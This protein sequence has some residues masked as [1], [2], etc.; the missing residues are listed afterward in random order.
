MRPKNTVF[1][2]SLIAI[3]A[4]QDGN[5][6]PQETSL[7]RHLFQQA[8]VF[9]DIGA[10]IGYF[11]CLARHAGTKTIAIEPLPENLN[12]LYANL[13]IN[14]WT[15]VEVLP[16]GLS[17]KPGVGTF[18]G[19]GTGASLLAGW[20]GASEV[21]KRAV[22]LTTLDNVLGGRFSGKKLI[23]KID[24]EG[25]EYGLLRGAMATIGMQPKPTWLIEICLTENQSGINPDFR[26]IFELFWGNGYDATN[27]C[28]PAR[29]ITQ[30]DVDRWI[31]NKRRDFGYVNYLFT[32]RK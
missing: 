22:A 16:L 25:A 13:M 9:V 20:A 12:V 29:I 8:D 6:E 1:G 23:I 31:K 19:G 24:V 2:F 10:N 32:A 17:D 18:Y 4:M 15:D 28:A 21:W 11:S 26:A 27:P 3:P 14:G 7:L 5:F 30:E